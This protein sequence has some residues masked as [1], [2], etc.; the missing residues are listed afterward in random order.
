MKL[1][2]TQIVRDLYFKYDYN[3]KFAN[4]GGNFNKYLSYLFE[5]KRAEKS[6]FYKKK[7]I[8]K[9]YLFDY[10]VYASKDIDVLF[11]KVPESSHL[12]EKQKLERE[13]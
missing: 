2:T 5:I 7:E 8:F 12:S 9:M 3:K 10:T 4:V 6:F 13:E 11:A 1:V